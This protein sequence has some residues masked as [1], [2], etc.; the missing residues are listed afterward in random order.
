M[1]ISRRLSRSLA[2]LLIVTIVVLPAQA[3]S[4]PDGPA[5]NVAYT[6]AP[7][8]YVFKAHGYI[9]QNG[10]KALE[11]DGYWFAAQTMRQFQQELLN[12]VRTADRYLGDHVIT[13]ELC[14]LWGLKC[15]QLF[16]DSI[17]IPGRPAE[18]DT[19]TIRRPAGD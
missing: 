4:P 14:V 13:V 19:I 18:T 10:I 3:W 15:W 6:P 5:P 11:N 8:A 17:P 2:P 16:D 7:G 9:I 1:R 12:G